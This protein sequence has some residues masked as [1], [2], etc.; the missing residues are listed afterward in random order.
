MD[1]MKKSV[2]ELIDGGEKDNHSCCEGDY[3]YHSFCKGDNQTHS[4]C[5]GDNQYHSYCEAIKFTIGKTVLKKHPNTT[6]II[7]EAGDWDLEFPQLIR[8]VAENSEK[9]LKQLGEEGR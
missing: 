6:K 9:V 4:Y 1:K 5:E 8:Y 2:Q 7:S 3:Q